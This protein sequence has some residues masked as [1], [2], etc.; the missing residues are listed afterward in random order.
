MVK[1]ET[2]IFDLL[3]QLLQAIPAAEYTIHIFTVERFHNKTYRQLFFFQSVSITVNS[4]RGQ[5]KAESLISG[6]VYGEDQCLT[7][8]EAMRCITLN[9]AWLLHLEDRL[10]SIETG[11][12]ADFT[13]LAEE[14]TEANKATMKDIEI[15]GTVSGGVIQ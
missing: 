4:L 10:G 2:V 1:N 15:I 7:A 11:K 14:V 9:A 8:D 13:V 5:D 3:T 12:W 6:K